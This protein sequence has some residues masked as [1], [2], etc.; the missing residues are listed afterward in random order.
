MCAL[1]LLSPLV[2]A[3]VRPPELFSLTVTHIE[4]LFVCVDMM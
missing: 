4:V 2:P 1:L 3:D